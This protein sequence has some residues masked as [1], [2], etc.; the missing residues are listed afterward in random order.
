MTELTQPATVLSVTDLTSHVRQ[1]VLRPKTQNI[2]F[3]PGQ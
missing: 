2:L 3:R 1:S